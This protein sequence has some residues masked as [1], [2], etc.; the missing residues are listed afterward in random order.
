VSIALTAV[1]WAYLLP[2]VIPNGSLKLDVDVS[3]RRITVY[4]YKPDGY[5]RDGRLVLVFHGLARNA[6]EYRDFAR[7]L[8]DRTGSIIAAREFDEDQFP[9][10]KYTR[11]GVREAGG[12]IASRSTWTWSLVPQIADALRQ[13][14]GRP[15]MAYY[16]VGHSAGGQFVVR[17]TGFVATGARG[18]V[19]ANPGAYLRPTREELFPY[20][21]GSLPLELSDDAAL[22]CYLAAPLTIFLGTNDDLDKT[23]EAD[24][25]GRDRLDRG[26]ETFEAARVLAKERGW[27]FRWRIIEAQGVGHAAAPC[28]TTP[29][30]P[31]RCSKASP[32]FKT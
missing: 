28:S 30:A 27:E 31:R 10:E 32:D 11:G 18:H 14:E 26:R 2:S 29:L 6:E 20:G 21:F 5:R 7:G 12:G 16:L 13:I 1:L 23:P 8:A 15:K 9:Y 4:T 19:A 17:L 25:Q 3:G 22:R 24:R